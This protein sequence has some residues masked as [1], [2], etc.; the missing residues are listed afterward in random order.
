MKGV[1]VCV[2]NRIFTG[3]VVPGD[4]EI[5]IWSYRHASFLDCIA[6]NGG[7]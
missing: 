4:T 1:N 7:M 3:A 2:C 5:F 6:Y